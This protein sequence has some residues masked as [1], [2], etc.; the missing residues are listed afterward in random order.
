MAEPIGALRAEMSAGYAQFVSD[1]KKA[2]DG[3]ATHGKGISDEMAKVRASFEGSMKSV[4]NFSGALKGLVA[5]ATLTGLIALVKHSIDAA[6]KMYKLAQ[7]TGVPV[8]ELSALAYAANLSDVEV[9][10]LAKSLEKLDRN[11]VKAAEGTGEAADA[12]AAMGISVKNTDGSLKSTDQ[13]LGEIADKFSKYK[14]GAE[15]TALAMAIFGKSGAAM[16][17]MLNRGSQGIQEMAEEARELG[18]VLSEESAAAAEQFNDN[19]KRLGGVSKGW[20]A[21]VRNEFLPTLNELTESLIQSAK[22]SG[23]LEKAAKVGATGIRLLVS[24]GIVTVGVFKTLGDGLAAIAALLYTSVATAFKSAGGLIGGVAESIMKVLGG[25]FSGAKET[26]TKTFD[27]FAQRV[28]QGTEAV[29]SIASDGFSDLVG[30]VK[31]AWDAL[32][33]TWSEGT[34]KLAPPKDTGDKIAAPIIKAVESSKEALQ[35]LQKEFAIIDKLQKDNYKRQDELL[36]AA[37]QAGLMTEEIYLKEKQ[38]LDVAY[39]EDEIQRTAKLLNDEQK[40]LDHFRGKDTEKKEVKIAVEGTKAKLEDL[41]RAYQHIFDMKSMQ[42]FKQ[43]NDQIKIRQNYALETKAVKELGETQLRYA[44]ATEDEQ[45]RAL[46]IADQKIEREKLA[47]QLWQ[48]GVKT[49]EEQAEILDLLTAKQKAVLEVF[50]KNVALKQ[51][52]LGGLTKGVND[53]YAEATNKFKATQDFAT[54]TFK[55]MEDALTNFIDTGKLDFTDFANSV[56]KDL[57][58]IFVQ[59]QI[60]GPLAK[61]T[62]T[63]LQDLFSGTSYTASGM[64]IETL[65]SAKGNVFDRGSVIPFARGGIVTRPTLFPMASGAGLMGEAGPEG[66]LPLKRMAGGNLGVN[67]AG[68]GVIVNIIDKTGADISTQS[69]QT[70]QGME[71]DVMIDQAVAKKLGQFGSSSNKSLK[72]TYGAKERLVTR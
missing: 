43:L 59:Q 6:D 34:A 10:D 23:G 40:L 38:A 7:A 18:L 64:K 49:A 68:G 30:N 62:G 16:I 5:G 17:P 48:E 20:I 3:A 65:T 44:S 53:Y 33:K 31:G 50:D 67:A 71:L 66:V 47:L 35:L 51:D 8:E 32:G 60:L 29:K 36:T 63:F 69:R 61:G 9:E 22:E 41:G 57:I 27:E 15:K 13:M 19:I 39:A 58:R 24:A 42:D 1:M 52:W 56:I 2:R 21:A 54:A 55:G 45:A 46:L 4:F 28:D 72:Q 12:F 25:D 11:M 70:N 37:R 26:I 14:D